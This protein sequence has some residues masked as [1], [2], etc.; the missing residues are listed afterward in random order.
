MTQ[1]EVAPLPLPFK[2]DCARVPWLPATKIRWRRQRTVSTSVFLS[3]TK[4]SL[5]RALPLQNSGRYRSSRGYFHALCRLD[6][7]VVCGCPT[8]RLQSLRESVPSL[9]AAKAKGR[10][11]ARVYAKY[12]VHVRLH[13]QIIQTTTTLVLVLTLDHDHIMLTFTF[14]CV[15]ILSSFTHIHATPYRPTLELRRGR[16]GWTGCSRRGKRCG[17]V[18]NDGSPSTRQSP[19]RHL[20][21]T[22][23]W[24]SRRSW[25]LQL[26]HQ[27]KRCTCTITCGLQ[28][29]AL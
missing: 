9:H 15:G 17:A 28:R 24:T 26:P 21:W 20:L 5:R 10:K 27:C 11:K 8:I 4:S 7:H 16:T 25:M 23:T 14:C 29:Q 18:P 3:M 22:W 13:V 6:V 2:P 1:A 19:K 12:T